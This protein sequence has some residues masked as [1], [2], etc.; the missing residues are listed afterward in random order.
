MSRN[1]WI[2][3][4]IAVVLIALGGLVWYNFFRDDSDS[5]PAPVAAAGKNGGF[6]LSPHDMTLG[7]RNAKV[8]LVEYAAPMCPH[9]ARFNEETFPKL[10]QTFIDT[11]K[12]FYVFRVLPIGPAD[13]P[14][15]TLA[16]CQPRDKYF[17]F[18]DLLFRNQQKWD[19]EYQVEDVRGGLLGLAKGFGMSEDAF[20]RCLADQ[21]ESDV[22]NQVAKDGVDR[23][24]L[25]STPSMVID[26][27]LR[28][29][30]AEWDALKAALDKEL[31]SK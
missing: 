5:M 13:G 3:A 29:G 27:S 8:T 4:V 14:A 24:G 22:I 11:G 31:A 18:I 30:L 20:N 25:E 28:P 2:L 6:V 16:R 9:C 12:V 17:A 21:H 19:P 15:E 26:G 7:N 10:K 1:S 23:Y